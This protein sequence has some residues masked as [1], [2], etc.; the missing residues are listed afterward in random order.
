MIHL[1]GTVKIMRRDFEIGSGRIVNL[2]AGKVKTSKVEEGTEFGMMV[3]SK[4]EVAPGDVLESFT[5]TK[6]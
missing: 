2:E 6:K 5:I 4:V 3:E 1:N